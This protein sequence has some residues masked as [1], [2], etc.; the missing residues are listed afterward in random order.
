MFSLKKAASLILAAAMMVSL[1]QVMPTEKMTVSAATY[2]W[3]SILKNDDSWFG[4]SE[5]I[6]LA[7]T[8]LQYQLDDGGWRKAMDDTSQT[9]S[10]AKSTIDNDT[11]TSQIRVLAR[12]YSQTGTQKYLDGCLDGIDLLIE[13]Q[14]DN[15]GWPQVFDDTGTYHAHITYNDTAMI[16]VMEL[17]TEVRDQEGDF[18]FVSDAYSTAANTAIDKGI[19]C[20][21][22]TQIVING[23]Y[24]GWCQQHDEY[25]LEPTSG[26]AYELAS[27]S[28][29]ESVGIVNYLRTIENPSVE[30]LNRINAAITWM[31]N[32]QLTGIAL[33]DYT[34]SDGE[35]DRRVIADAD[36]DPLWARF[37]YL[38]DGTT[39]LFADRQ[40]V[41]ADNWDHIGAERRTGYAW[42][43]TWPKSLVAEGVIEIAPTVLN[44]TLIQ[45][46]TIQDMTYGS[47]W[48]IDQDLQN[49]EAVYGDR[50]RIY[51]TLPETLV[52]AEYIRT[53]CDSKYTIGTLA[54]FTAG[55]DIDVYAAFDGR[56]SPAPS[57]LSDWTD[58]G[59]TAMNDENVTFV[60]YKKSFSAGETITLGENGQS[61]GCV[62]YTV[63]VTEQPEEA[64]PTEPAKVRGDV[65]ADG[66]FST[67]D[68]VMM[69]KWLLAV[70]GLTDWQAG[71][72]CEDGVINAFDLA[73]MKREL[74]EKRAVFEVADNLFD[75][76]DTDTLGLSYPAGLQTYTVWKAE[77]EGD[78]Y[79]NG[80][81]LAGYGGK[82]YCMWQSSETNEDSAD[83][84]V[85][86]AVSA[87][88]GKTW[89]EPQ[90]LVQDIAVAGVTGDD[91]AYCSSGGWLAADDQLV[92]YINVW[93]GL[94]PRGGF[95][96]YMTTQDGT[97]WSDPKPVMM[98]DGTQMKAIFEQDPHVLEDGR[99]VNA[100]HFQDGLIVSPIY[101]DDPNGITGWKKGDFTANVSG[102]TSVEMEPS[103]FVQSDGTI[104]MLFRDQNS[105]Y[106]KLASYSRDNGET[107]SKVQSTE[108]P[109]ART[110]QSAGNLSDGTAFMAGCP[111]NNSLRSPLAVTLS[112]DGETFDQ[113]YLL[114][115]SSSDPELIYEGTAKRKGFHYCKSLVYGGYLYVGYA[116]NK[117]A[118]EISVV[119]EESLMLN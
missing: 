96:Y 101:T 14:Y 29:S 79:C 47:S 57:W 53:A 54:Y 3:S 23:Q 77:E 46:L 97:N 91:T 35:A 118:V 20:I 78:H 106:T 40:G 7:D 39:P 82:L 90:Q 37:Y 85:V 8:I 18:T 116:T 86:Y 55:A 112:A 22:D 103:L 30:I 104:V 84:R 109:D 100:A 72:L 1:T 31:T 83:T 75:Q 56:V 110:K 117:E 58:S 6:V 102:S 42:Y 60:L 115:S 61:S 48:S 36:A 10:W 87:D 13:G 26:R 2:S 38:T 98:A 16:H 105:S 32:A 88:G 43:G 24:T 5:G 11:T 94:D 93:P 71:D 69:Q 114:R 17:L 76:N 70:G 89:T 41:A 59:M 65:N 52:G 51:V 45:E 92:A 108:M 4:S 111:V 119:P 19:Q 73:A 25:T 66:A 81:S 33:E 15:G 63:F 64:L 68:I 74:L 67:A 99:I 49:G 12:V 27:I 113:A 50:D 21:L 9:G 95:T 34:N 107:W 62:G 44:G 28:S 80:V